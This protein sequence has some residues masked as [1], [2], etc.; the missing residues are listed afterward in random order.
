MTKATKDDLKW[1]Y[2]SCRANYIEE[3]AL[4]SHEERLETF[5]FFASLHSTLLDELNKWRKPLVKTCSECP[6]LSDQPN[7]NCPHTPASFDAS[8]APS[9]PISLRGLELTMLANH[10][11]LEIIVSLAEASTSTCKDVDLVWV[12]SN[13]YGYGQPT[14]GMSCEELLL[15][16]ATFSLSYRWILRAEKDR[17][18]QARGQVVD[19]LLAQSSHKEAEGKDGDDCWK[20]EEEKGKGNEKERGDSEKDTVE[21]GK[22]GS[23]LNP[24]EEIRSYQEL[25]EMEMGFQK[26]A[27]AGWWKD[28]DAPLSTSDRKGKKVL[29]HGGNR[30]TAEEEVQSYRELEVMEMSF[31][32]DAPAGWSKDVEMPQTFPDISERKKVVEHGGSGAKPADERLWKPENREIPQG[33]LDAKVDDEKEWTII[34]EAV[35]K[36]LGGK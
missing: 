28:V 12:A 5:Q 18:S 32:A 21:Y 30:L 36:G 27:P 13:H 1:I 16:F 24:E 9:V 31:Q 25:E 10:R 11:I 15:M 14:I 33:E 34:W 22:D 3:F 2:M 8:A 35:Q 4:L 26:N 17:F 29:E 20:E 7:P 19:A 6:A 23:V